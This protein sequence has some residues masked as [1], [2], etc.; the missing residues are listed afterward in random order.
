MI[1]A[2]DKVKHFIAGFFVSFV[3]EFFA[4]IPYGTLAAA[5]VGVGKELIWDKA[6][7]KGTPSADDAI[8]TLMGGVL[9]SLLRH[10]GLLYLG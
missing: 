4:P 2:P 8:A 9:A 3:V 7:K 5:V 10:F 1:V 6:M